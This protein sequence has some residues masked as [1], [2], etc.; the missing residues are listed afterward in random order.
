MDSLAEASSGG[1]KLRNY[2]GA[3]R[4]F[5][6]GDLLTFTRIVLVDFGPTVVLVR[7]KSGPFWGAFSSRTAILTE[8]D[9]YALLRRSPKEFTIDDRS[10][11]VRARRFPR[12]KG[13][14]ETRAIV[15]DWLRGEKAKKIQE[16]PV[17]VITARRSGFIATKL[18][19]VSIAEGHHDGAS[20]TLIEAELSLPVREY[21]G[22]E[23]A[24]GIEPAR[25]MWKAW[26]YG[27]W[28]A[29]GTVS[30][31]ERKRR[32]AGAL[33]ELSLGKKRVAIGLSV[34]VVVVSLWAA[35]VSWIFH[36]TG[37]PYESGSLFS[38]IAAGVGFGALT[39]A[40]VWTA[41]GF[42]RY[43]AGRRALRDL[44]RDVTR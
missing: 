21:P 38:T 11:L 4:M 18:I 44:R 13:L 6:W 3:M 29:L 43:H 8:E 37:T 24:G 35:A 31:D 28:Y 41:Y 26:L 10:S 1:F 17:G 33:A 5:G 30:T 34:C 39:P 36:T 15:V 23:H 16:S 42:G 19:K 27:L 2:R 20:G 40:G 22:L 14:P 25:A 32:I 7:L 9:A 12:Q